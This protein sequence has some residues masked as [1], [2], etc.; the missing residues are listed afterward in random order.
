MSNTF[1]ARVAA[2]AR[3][4]TAAVFIG[5]AT[6]TSVAGATV[7]LAAPA[8]ASPATGVEAAGALYGQPDAAAEYWQMQHLADDCVLMT[9]ADVVGQ[10]TGNLPSEAEIVKLAENTPSVAHPGSIY[11]PPTQG[12]TFGTDPSDVV[13]LLAHYGIEGAI[14]NAVTED[15]TGVRTG[16]VAIEQYLGGGH[17]VIATINIETIWDSAEGDRTAPDHSVVVTGVDTRTGMVHLNDPA[18][19]E[20]RDKQVTIATF[21]QAWKASDYQMVVTVDDNQPSQP[22]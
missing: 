18:Y 2:A 7:G 11:L 22:A 5:A 15:Q 19:S 9:V 1:L 16:L 14:T 4:A 21:M 12:R 10:V 17:R 6:A 8:M 13:V 20:G 3:A